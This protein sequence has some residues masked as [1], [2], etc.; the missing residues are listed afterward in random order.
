MAKNTFGAK[1]WKNMLAFTTPFFKR[2]ETVLV[3]FSGGPDSV[4]LMHFLRYLA[5]KKHFEIIAVHVHHGLRG[6]AADKDAAFC[7][8]LCKTWDI[9]FI[10]KKKNVR[11]LAKKLDLSIEHAARKAR[12]EAFAQAARSTG[13]TKLA[14]GHHLDDQAETVLLN[15]LR[16]TQP[17]GLCGIPVRRM[18][19][20]KVEI[21]RPLLCITRAEVQE[22]LQENNLSFVTDE[23]NFDET[24][25]RN[26]VRGELLPL[27]ESKQP[28]IRQHL[29]VMAQR[30]SEKL[31]K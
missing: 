29:A 14:L 26:W 1:T 25:R 3:G 8:R 10:L 28:Q 20:K 21:V 22:Y 2:G 16:G 5:G 23:T 4:C 24:Y 6:K 11:S 19:N 7:R 31:K 27:L 30:L 15:L 17:E 9:P 18:L 12:Y 13:A